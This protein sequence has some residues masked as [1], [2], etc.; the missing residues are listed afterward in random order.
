MKLWR[1]TGGKQHR[2]PGRFL[3]LPLAAALTAASAP[4]SFEAMAAEGGAS[5]TIMM[6]LCG[7]DLESGGGAATG[8]IEEA[9]S[10]DLGGNVN[11]VMATGGATAWQNEVVDPN[12][13]S[14]FHIEDG[15]LVCDAQNDLVSMGE[16]STLSNFISWG[17][18]NFPAEKYGLIMWDHGSGS[19]GGLCFDEIFENDSLLLPEYQQ[20]LADSGVHFEMIGMDTCLMASLET[21]ARLDDYACY[22]VGSEESE[23]GSGWDYTDFLTFLR[24]N[25]EADGAELGQRI[26]DGFQAKCDA[27]GTGYMATLS[28][29]DLSKVT[30]V[31]EA[32]RSMTNEML[33]ST[34]DSSSFRAVCQGAGSAESYGGHSRSEGYSN[35]VDLVDFAEKTQDVLPAAA[36]IPA[37]VSDA[38]I[39]SVHGEQREGSSGMS[40]V[41]PYESDETTQEYYSYISDNTDYQQYMAILGGNYDA[42][43]WTEEAYSD[44]QAEKE[45]AAQA[46]NEAVIA[47]VTEN[48]GQET[49]DELTAQVSEL[50]Y[51]TIEEM[52]KAN[53][54]ASV[55]AFLSE[56]TGLDES[57][58]QIGGGEASEENGGEEAAGD[59]GESAED[60]GDEEA[61]AGSSEDL[62]GAAPSD[63]S[64]ADADAYAE[65]TLGDDF[66]GFLEYFQSIGY[67]SLQDV[68]D[69]NG[70][71]NFQEFMDA[72]SNDE[73]P[74]ASGGDEEAGS[75]E[76]DDEESYETDEYCETEEAADGAEAEGGSNGGF[77]PLSS[78][79]FNVQI[80]QEI[81]ENNYLNLYVTDGLDSIERADFSIMYLEPDTGDYIFLGTDSDLDIDW[82]EGRFSDNFRGTW[83]TIGGEYVCA[84][85]LDVTDDYNLYTI[86]ARVNGE[87]TNI[88]AMYSFDDEA[89][90]VLGTYSGVDQ[91]TGA[92]ARDVR[93][94]EDGDEVVFTFITLDENQEA[95]DPYETEPITWS[96]DVVMEDL[97]LFDGDYYYMI[98]VYDF[99][100]NEY[101]GDPVQMTVEDGNISASGL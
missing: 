77:K 49:A 55:E 101:Q 50:G 99:F 67:S 3:V 53:G 27:G 21:A 75:D 60:T 89:F 93:P 96:D 47:W 68:M 33:M 64:S 31:I 79:D 80:E 57:D 94:L 59:G 69:Q 7:S 8:N 1:G 95:T 82:D 36:D 38:V 34:Q 83:I 52:V 74:E 42:S 63:I 43:N 28:V 84:Y 23:P 16:S 24:E 88:R 22:M 25:P 51:S 20:G 30:P 87:D 85:L 41:Y 54:Y 14:Y 66:A 62:S 61:G 44:Q 11:V 26:C 17:A 18:S 72:V 5:W 10:A 58:I 98:S 65:Q 19:L 39:Y 9:L 37:V 81:D 70:F 56:M 12:Y 45:A 73:I 76:S 32:W 91:Q 6:Y 2:R 15:Q 4:W 78:S 86:P 29:I 100:G 90:T 48:L 46:S 40:V 35:M 92:S 13:I 97:D 71:S